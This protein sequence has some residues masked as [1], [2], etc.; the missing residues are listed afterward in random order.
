MFF[1]FVLGFS[2]QFPSGVRCALASYRP[3]LKDFFRQF[4]V[5]SGHEFVRSIIKTFTLIGCM[6]KANS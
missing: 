4:S 3:A 6:F 2:K 5:H 1:S